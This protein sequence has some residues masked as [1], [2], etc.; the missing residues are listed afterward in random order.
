MKYQVEYTDTFGGD[1]NYSWCDRY[2]VE[3]PDN[4]SKKQIRRAAKKAA[5][6]SGIR[7]V[8]DTW[9]EVFSFRPYRSCTILFA[10]YYEGAEV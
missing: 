9:G 10:M 2:I 1:A 8:W 5:G 4:A 3:L 7:G 6:L